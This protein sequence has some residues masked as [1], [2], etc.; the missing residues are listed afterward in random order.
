MANIIGGFAIV[1]A[2]QTQCFDLESGALLAT[3][4]TMTDFNLEDGMTVNYL[5]GDYG[6]KKLLAFYGDRDTKISVGTASNTI[7]L[8]GLMTNT[9]PVSGAKEVQQ[10]SFVAEIKNSEVKLPKEP[11][12]ERNFEVWKL[13]AHG[14]REEK[15]TVVATALQK[16]QC[17]V[18]GNI[19]TFADTEAGNVEVFYY[20]F[21]SKITT[22]SPEDIRPKAHKMVL[23]LL[24]QSVDTKKY[25]TA[26]MTI[27]NA[28][29][30][31]TIKL[32]GSNTGD[33]PDNVSLEIE[34]LVS[35]L[36]KAPYEIDINE[37]EATNIN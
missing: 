26:I 7:E 5:K 28:S 37:E 24:L 33:V 16:G 3:I 1:G 21:E 9:V 15:L 6:N 11:V 22:I 31:P 4:D 35:R 27:H 23:H 17:S 34:A 30:N 14:L 19:L 25:H 29:V 20:A 36:H 8:L 13:N 10:E 12:L 18:D 32:S 2:T